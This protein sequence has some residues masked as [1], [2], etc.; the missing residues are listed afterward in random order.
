MVMKTE[1]DSDNE[2]EQENLDLDYKDLE[3][4]NDDSYVKK[5]FRKKRVKS[6]DL[7]R[8]KRAQRAEKRMKEEFDENKLATIDEKIRTFEHQIIPNPTN[9]RETKMNKNIEKNIAFQKAYREIVTTGCSNRKAASKVNI[10]GK[11]CLLVLYLFFCISL[12]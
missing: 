3:S 7:K 10:L 6:D 2:F 4:H 1:N 5:R 12:G 9:E 8:G 11:F